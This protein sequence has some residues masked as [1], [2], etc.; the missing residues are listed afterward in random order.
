MRSVVVIFLAVCFGWAQSLTQVSVQFQW[1]HQFQFAGY[2]AA[3]EMGFYEDAGFEVKLKEWEQGIDMVDEVLA[4]RADYAVARSTA[5]IDKQKGSDIVA[6]FATFQSSPLVYLTTQD[7]GIETLEDFEHKRVMTTNDLERD[8]S[9]IAMLK[10][11]GVDFDSMQIQSPSFNINDLIKGRTDIITSYISNEPF[12]LQQRGYEPVVFDPKEYGF[13]FY[14]DLLITSQDNIQNNPQNVAAFRKATMKGWEYAFDNIEQIA[15][16]IEQKY[17][18]QNK[19]LELLVYEGNKL[20]ELAYYQ[21]DVFGHID[22]DKIKRTL[23]VYKLLGVA[24]S[25]FDY[26]SFIYGSK[27]YTLG[28]SEKQLRYLREKERIRVCTNPDFVPIEFTREGR[29]QG[30][31]IDTLRLLASMLDLKLKVVTTGSWVQSQQYLREKK[32]DLLPSASVTPGREEFAVFTKPYLHMELAVVTRDD[33]PFVGT[34]ETLEDEEGVRKKGSAL[35]ELLGDKY[36][37]LNLHTSKTIKAMFDEVS[38]GRSYYT[39]AS[40][41]VISHYVQNYGYDNLQIAGYLPFDYKMSMAIRDD[42]PYLLGLLNTA[43]DAA[44]QDRLEAIQ[45]DWIKLSITEKS[46]YT[47]FYKTVGVLLAVVVFFIIHNLLLRRQKQKVVRAVKEKNE[48]YERL[49]LA[50]D[51]ARIYTFEYNVADN[52]VLLCQKLAGILTVSSGCSRE[53]FFKAVLTSE[54]DSFAQCF[55]KALNS[56]EAIKCDHNFFDRQGGMVYMVISLKTIR[57]SAGGNAMKL[58]GTLLDMSEYKQMQDELIGAKEDAEDATKVKS[59]FLANMSHELRTPLNAI[60]G[61]T[62]LLQKDCTR[63]R[64]KEHIEKI[65]SASKSLMTIIDDILDFSRLE[66]DS[67][68]LHRKVFNLKELIYLQFENF[69][70]QIKS[71][72]LK[73]EIKYPAAVE[74]N[75]YADSYRLSQLLHNLISN[76]VKFTDE[77]KITVGID[78]IKERMYQISVN[79]TGIG[80]DKQH[81]ETLFDS[82]VQLDESSSRKYGGT[83]IGLALTKQLVHLMHGSIHVSSQKGL[84]TSFIIQLPLAPS[85]KNPQPKQSISPEQPT[86]Q[87]EVEKSSDPEFEAL[88]HELLAGVNKKRPGRYQPVLQKLQTYK[89]DAYQQKVYERIELFLQ[90]YDFKKTI[91]E[92]EKALRE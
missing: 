16:L 36:P 24:K 48:S 47:H 92:I 51:L 87:P 65:Q 1:K 46:G 80:M 71:K 64:D 31:S 45:K 49:R 42:D 4:G 53:E 56:S 70:T 74:Q 90:R 12:Q 68:Q 61:M 81:L 7:R 10:S 55:Q 58:I 77:G 57:F 69:D 19:S 20:K 23:D 50:L 67:M 86:G 78:K 27:K 28:L 26:D 76:A 25:G 33:A 43:I 60:T 72:G 39:V 38:S 17:N 79:D 3:K 75:F 63:H 6:L 66:D 82:F 32:C 22:R 88:L 89:K 91:D 15:K 13:D 59:N 2:Y 62:Y 52:E 30:I 85:G 29:V 37:G 40:L 83:G 84:G 73:V 21:T 9:L 44:G 34:I 18:T 41:P 5:V 35:V 14:N 11:S 8:A 54:Q